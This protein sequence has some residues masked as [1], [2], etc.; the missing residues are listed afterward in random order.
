MNRVRQAPSRPKAAAA[1][2][3][4]KPSTSRRSTGNQDGYRLIVEAA[5]SALLLCDGQERVRLC[6]QRAA[7]LFGYR[8][9]ADLLARSANLLGLLQTPESER[10]AADMAEALQRG[11]KEAMVYRLTGKGGTEF[12]GEITF[13]KIEGRSK[14]MVVEIRDVTESRHHLEALQ[15]NQFL[16][17][18]LVEETRHFLFIIDREDKVCYVNESGAAHLG[19]SAAQVIGQPRSKFFPESVA[20]RQRAA[21]DTVFATGSPQYDE[22]PVSYTSPP[23]WLGTF[24]VPIRDQD[25][26]VQQVL[27]ISTDITSRIL[28]EQKLHQ[29][30]KRFHD[31]IERSL[32]GYA[33]SDEIGIIRYANEALSQITGYK[34]QELLGRNF[35]YFLSEPYSDLIRRAFGRVMGGQ[36]ISRME[37]RLRQKSGRN[38]WITFN[39]RRVVQDGRVIGAEAFVRNTT[40]A[41]KSLE[42]LQQ[43]EVR[44]R[45][46]FNFIPVEV[47]D[48]TAQ[49]RIRAA[50]P[51]FVQNWGNVTGRLFAEVPTDEAIQRLYKYLVN[52]VVQQ[53]LTT[54]YN[55]SLVRDGHTVFYTITLSPILTLEGKLIGLVGTNLNNTKQIESYQRAR[56]LS[57][58][59]VRIQED[60]RSHLSREIHDSLGQY[61][62]ALQM[63]VGA[64][65]AIS[66]IADERIA[67]ML[68]NTKTTINEA[69]KVSRSMVQ[70]LRTPVLDDFGL[71]AAVLDFISELEKKWHYHISFKS[72][73]LEEPLPRELETTLYRVLQEACTNVIK[74]GRTNEIEIRLK[75]MSGRVSLAVRDHGVGFEADKVA[76]GQEHFGLFSMKERVELL[77][78]RF[79]ILSKPMQGVLIIALIPYQIGDQK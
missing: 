11:K 35:L 14:G 18:V 50:N 33:F 26:R 22:S 75:R 20:I 15:Q 68:E 27:G 23:I 25:Q 77:E 43:S 47:F 66:P 72:V 6:N 79:R 30:E 36:S 61:L 38:I 41:K 54:Q 3:R 56:L 60:E 58:R 39:A 37:V 10:L 44:F 42:A 2:R 29:S 76:L 48:L 28:V 67:K 73:N 53:H 17:R 31:T 71:K 59:L 16:S 21:L 49:G 46:L 40:N 57:A 19:L 65:T 5:G 63:E 51:A 78:G 1:Q 24:L 62:S 45:S 7:E 74:H 70:L 34:R 12:L 52:S 9:P 4:D 55:Y 8:H 69:V 64:L 13:A 32:D